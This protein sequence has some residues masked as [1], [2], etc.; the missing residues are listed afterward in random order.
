[1]PVADW[2]PD[3][4][5]LDALAAEAQAKLSDFTPQVCAQVICE[6]HHHKTT[7]G[8]NTNPCAAQNMSNTVMAYA[9]FDHRPAAL[10]PVLVAEVHRKLPLFSPQVRLGLLSKHIMCDAM[11]RDI[12][13]LMA[14]GCC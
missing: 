14:A 8:M 6:I 9:R 5:L 4:E 12:P 7:P 3:A 11:R 2:K 10:L 13:A 1:M